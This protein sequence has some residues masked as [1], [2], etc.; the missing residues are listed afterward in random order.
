MVSIV[1]VAVFSKLRT[2]SFY[3]HFLVFS[4]SMWQYS[5]Y[6]QA[7]VI[8]TAEISLLFPSALFDNVSHHTT[9]SETDLEF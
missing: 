7:S 2:N 1:A 6:Q 4:D 5:L 3:V 8:Q 9:W